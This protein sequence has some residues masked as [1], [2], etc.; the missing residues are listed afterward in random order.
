MLNGYQLQSF[1]PE[2]IFADTEDGI[3]LR[4]TLVHAIAT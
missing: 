4:K 1:T 3:N 2:E